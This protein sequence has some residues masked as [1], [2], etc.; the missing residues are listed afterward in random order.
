MTNFE[1]GEWEKV[2]RLS[3]EHTEPRILTIDDDAEERLAV[4][5]VLERERLHV[6]P[7]ESA[8][9]GLDNLSRSHFDLV[10]TDLKMRKKNGLDVVLETRNHGIYVPFILLTASADLAIRR[11]AEQMGVAVLDKPVHKHVLINQVGK[12][13]SDSR[14]SELVPAFRHPCGVKCSFSFDSFCP[15]RP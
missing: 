8:E 14:R 9:Q 13:L 3:M 7:A 15:S 12:A 5:W 1:E 2:R 4:Q 6:T 10:I 11:V